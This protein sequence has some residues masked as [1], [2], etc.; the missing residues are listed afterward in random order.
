MQH[1]RC[2]HLRPF[3]PAPSAPPA[4]GCTASPP[5][6]PPSPRGPSQGGRCGPGAHLSRGARVQQGAARARRSPS[7]P[8]AP[9]TPRRRGAGGRPARPSRAPGGGGSGS[10]RAAAPTPAASSLARART[11]SHTCA[12]SGPLLPARRRRRGSKGRAWELRPR[13]LQE[14][15]GQVGG[16]DA[17]HQLPPGR[18]R[19]AGGPRTEPPPRAARPRRARGGPRGTRA[20]LGRRGPC[21]SASSTARW[22]RAARGVGESGRPQPAHPLPPPRPPNFGAGESFRPG[23]SARSPGPALPRRPAR[24]RRPPPLSPEPRGQPPGGARGVG[25]PGTQVLRAGAP[26]RPPEV[27][28]ASLAPRTS[29]GDPGRRVER[30]GV[31]TWC[32]GGGGGWGRVS[33][34][35]RCSQVSRRAA[36][37]PPRSALPGP[38]R[39]GEGR[40]HAEPGGAGCGGPGASQAGGCVG[41]GAAGGHRFHAAAVGQSD[42]PLPSA[43]PSL[44][45]PRVS[46]G[47]GVRGRGPLRTRPSPSSS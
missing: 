47:R 30:E 44:G 38:P 11:A 23:G 39:C 25:T 12:G 15:G 16:R 1:P 33:R 3:P 32:R 27:P 21:R 43:V 2:R 6:R 8:R 19:Q 5:R 18:W 26:G 45:V 13:R 36:R 10:A 22:V 20:R 31:P 42:Q 9:R 24:A 7:P 40:G 46:A 41:T 29:E 14:A 4:P 28:E 17:E 35:E 34:S 37:S